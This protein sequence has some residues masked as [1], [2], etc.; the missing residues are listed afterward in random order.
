MEKHELNRRVDG[1]LARFSSRATRRAY[2]TDL[3]E[4]F[5]FLEAQGGSDPARLDP[6]RL[7]PARLDRLAV[8]AWLVGLHRRLGR[9]SIE[10][11]VACLRSFFRYLKREGLIDSD[12]LARLK[13]PRKEKKTS[14]H[15]SVDEAFALLDQGV[16]GQGFIPARDRAILEL[17]YSTGLRVGELVGLECESVDRRLG[18]VR[19]FGKG[20]RERVVPLGEKA[21]RRLEEYQNQAGDIRAKTG[22]RALFLNQRGGRLSDRYVRVILDKALAR[23][24]A[25]RRISPHGLRH[26]FAT[27]LLNNGADIRAVQQMLGH[28]SLSTTQKYTHTSIDHLIRVYD[29]AHPRSER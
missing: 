12:P 4:F 13:A 23:L 17:L 7:D 27:H 18:M 19:I 2:R 16:E 14:P 6:T 9:A 22:A 5:D 29:R 11:K 26:S 15:L 28:Q 3:R 1:F 24:A 10:R 25:A 21:L 20:G 8:R